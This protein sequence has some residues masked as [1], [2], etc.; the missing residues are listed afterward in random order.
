[1]KL[2]NIYEHIMNILNVMKW[3][4]VDLSPPHLSS[5]S[6]LGGMTPIFMWSHEM[7]INFDHYTQTP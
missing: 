7:E 5:L 1:M 2:R 6:Y 3:H 4:S